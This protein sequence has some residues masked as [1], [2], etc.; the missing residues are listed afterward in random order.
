MSST[1]NKVRGPGRPPK[2]KN[3]ACTWCGETKQPLKYVLP[4]QHGKK[5]FCS[6]TCLSE[7][8]KTYARGA[9]V[10]CDNVIRG[11]PFRLEQKDGPTKDFCSSFCLNAY[12]KKE[13][14]VDIKKNNRDPSS[15]SPAPSPAPSGLPSNNNV[16]STTQS[17]TNNHAT[18]SHSPST[19]TGTF[20]TYESCPTFDWDLY[21]KE[22]NSTAAPIECFK[23]HDIPPTNEFE[24]NMKLEALD[25]RNLTSTCIATVIAVTGPRLRLRLDGSDN[26]N[27]FWRL[28]D[29]NE[30]HAIGHCEKS[31]GM[32]QPPLGFRMNAS[33]WPM[34]L[35]KTLNG[36][37]MAPAKVFKREPKTPRCNLFKIGYKLE[38]VDRKNPQLICTATVG[39]VKDDLIHITFDG[40]RGAFD[41]W[42]RYDSRDI[43]PAGWCFKS[44]HP[45]Q[46]PRQ[47]SGSN[48]FRSRSTSNNVTLVMGINENNNNTNRE[49]AVALVS[50]TGSTAQPQPATEPDTSTANTKPLENVTL[51]VNHKCRCGPYF[52][53]RKVKAM[54]AQFGSGPIPNV[55]RDIFQ[56]FL[57]AAMNPRQMLSLLRNGNGESITLSMGTLKKPTTVKLPVFLEEEDF[58]TYIRQQL[59]D[60]RACEYILTRRKEPCSKCSNIPA[61]EQPQFTNSEEA[62]NSINISLGEKRKWTPESQQNLTSTQQQQVQQTTVQSTNISIDSSSSPTSTK[63]A[64]KSVPELEA[65]TST[66]QSETSGTRTPSTEPAEWTI[67]DVI[68]YIAITDPA[69]GQ[70]ADL[71]R[72]HE[73][74]G[75]ALL[76]LNSDMMMKY[77]GL[78]L[79]PALKICNLVN[80]IKGRRHMLM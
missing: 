12:Q 67:E 60:L 5:E 41:Y 23:Q 53:F 9:C 24:I 78:K 4:M 51:Y 75:K 74:D 28:V 57:M 32:L 26:K 7:S 16:P 55:A 17:Y 38:A 58:Y 69:L 61:Q 54:P 68:N 80:R 65:A 18:V 59:K 35:L 6:E 10:Q 8:R 33:M 39:A 52:D 20:K 79:G 45:L 71:F 29:S 1:Q 50:P 27:D 34:F 48:K 62:N 30:I 76:L 40:W 3:S 72:K 19:S 13:I 22:T 36:A 56:A 49:H 21:L 14:Q 11:T 15:P 77:M 63:Q 64:R 25:P 42:C 43:F 2:S 31:G 73:I 37:E 46:P 44:G 47:K 70:H 66:T